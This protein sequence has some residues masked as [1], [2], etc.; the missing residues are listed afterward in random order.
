MINKL[1]GILVF[2]LLSFSSVAS[3]QAEREANINEQDPAYIAQD[4]NQPVE[5]R[6]S[7]LEY[8]RGA[9]SQN[10]VIAIARALKEDNVELNAAAIVG[11]EGL[12][13]EYRWRMLLPFVENENP[14]LK[15]G[16]IY[17]LTKGYQQLDSDMKAKLNQYSTELEQY[18]LQQ[19]DLSSSIKLAE[20]YLAT[21]QTEKAIAQFTKLTPVAADNHSIWIGLSESY[22]LQND[23]QKALIALQEGIKNNPE[24][25]ALYYAKSLTLIRLNERLAA[26]SDIESA[27]M[28]AESNGYYWYLYAVMQKDVDMEKAVPLF[29]RAYQLTASP[30]YLYA[31]CEVYVEAKDE[32]SSACLAE[33]KDKSPEAFNALNSQNKS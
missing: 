7:A 24:S 22:R 10:A 14:T 4:K 33:L 28:L 31:L 21:Q 18:Y 17:S 23:E 20:V 3:S 26:L 9:P 19:S 1:L 29:E 2:A 15:Y 32:A 25:S 5:L 27:A 12:P 30:Q 6:V 11:S 8:L 13:M 16:A